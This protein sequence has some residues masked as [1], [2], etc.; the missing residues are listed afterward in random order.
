VLV[1]VAHTEC[2]G[3]YVSLVL[4]WYYV[5]RMNCMLLMKQMRSAS[6]EMGACV[7]VQSNT[8]T[9]LLHFVQ[10]GTGASPRALVDNP[11]LRTGRVTWLCHI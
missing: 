6:R 2:C 4:P 9:C 7:V 5:S 11:A 3:L 10:A 8:T 1:P